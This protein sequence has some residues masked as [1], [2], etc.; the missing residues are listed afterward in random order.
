MRTN[1]VAKFARY[2]LPPTQSARSLGSSTLTWNLKDVITAQDVSMTFSSASL[3]ETLAKLYSFAP[4][5]LLLAAVFGAVWAWLRGL[6]AAPAQL[7][8]AVLAVLSGLTLG[9]VSMNYLLVG[10]AGLI[11]SAVGSLLALR[12]LGAGVVAA[13]TDGH[14]L[15]A[16]L[17]AGGQRRTDH[18][19]GGR[20]GAG[21]TD[22]GAQTRLSRQCA[23]LTAQPFPA[24]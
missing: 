13:S 10:W 22:L 12:A 14:R 5:A 11:G 8:L 7:A 4:L 9:G 1:E 15:A 17:F 23:S 20:P 6:R 2:S 19:A 18:H 3:R 21:G 16:G 24:R